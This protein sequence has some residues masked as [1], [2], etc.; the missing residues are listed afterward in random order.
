M[1]N[2]PFKMKG[3]TPL[4]HTR[5]KHKGSYPTGHTNADHPNYWKSGESKLVNTP[6]G[7]KGPKIKRIK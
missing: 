4:K 7:V 1:A 6:T 2:T 5:T 3:I